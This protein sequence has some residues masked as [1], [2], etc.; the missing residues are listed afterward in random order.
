MIRFY[1]FQVVK[2]NFQMEKSF[3][4]NAGVESQE[5]T[6][7][8]NGKSNV[9][10]C[11]WWS[12]VVC[13]LHYLNF[14]ASTMA[15]S[16]CVQSF[17]EK[18]SLNRR[19]N[20]CMWFKLLVPFSSHL[21]FETLAVHSC[22]DTRTLFAICSPLKC[23][24]KTGQFSPSNWCAKIAKYFSCLLADGVYCKCARKK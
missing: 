6:L 15:C 2:L 3:A 24:W 20:Q 16:S 18:S 7:Y 17:G 22:S 8:T 14:K 19:S 1:Q 9:L 5:C 11:I 12:C 21:Y 13:L 10:S 23:W 4:W